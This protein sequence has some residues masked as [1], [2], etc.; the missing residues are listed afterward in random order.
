MA[1]PDYQTIMLP[2]LQHIGDKKEHAHAETIEHLAKHFK[3]TEADL[4]IP[5]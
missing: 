3:L 5:V 4:L 1:I 2:L